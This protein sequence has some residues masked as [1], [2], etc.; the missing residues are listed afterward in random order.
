MLKDIKHY[1]K[2][3]LTI[4]LPIIMGNIGF[5]LIGIGDVIIAG[6]HSTD[7]FA[8][9]SIAN[10]IISCLFTFGIGIIASISPLLSNYRGQNKAIKKYF[11][12]SIRFAMLLSGVTTLLIIACIPLIPIMGFEQHL[13]KDIQNY[14]WITAFSTFGGYLHACLKEFLQAFEIVIFPN[15]LTLF[16]V[17][18]NLILN[19]VF[20]FGFGVI[21]S[22]GTIGLAVS[23]FIVRYFMGFALLVYCFINMNLRNYSERGYYKSLLEIG[24]PISMAILVEFVAFNSIAVFM[25]RVAGVYAAA[26]NLVCT[27]TTV[28][29]MI[30]FAISNAMAVKVGYANGAENYQDLKRYC[31]VGIIMSEVFMICSSI[32]FLTLP[33]QLVGLFTSDVK[34]YEITLPVMFV[35][36]GFQLFDGLQISLSG[37]CKGLKQTDIVLLSNFIAYWLIAIPLGYALAFKFNFLLTGFWIGLFASSIVLCVIMFLRL[38]PKFKDMGILQ[39]K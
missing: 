3:L 2:D 5:I 17:V 31:I 25:G 10:A 36:V 7:T 34:L 11:Y 18:L 20:V 16:C 35:L 30:P 22:M 32:V 1:A 23:S 6:R 29:F 4:A 9:I 8:S 28:S 27:L 39:T 14:M 24:L 38:Y 33:K 26:Q 37:I 19:I 15:I 12:P 13:V 21:P